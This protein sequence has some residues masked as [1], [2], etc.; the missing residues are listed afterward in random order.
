VVR[1][2]EG[3]KE[4]TQDRSGTSA[5]GPWSFKIVKA[6]NR[7]NS[8]HPLGFRV[9][10]LIGQHEW[11]SNGET[12]RHRCEIQVNLK[13]YV[14]AKNENTPNYESIRKAL[15]DICKGPEGISLEKG[16]A[17][18]QHCPVSGSLG[19]APLVR[20][21]TLCPVRTRRIQTSD[22]ACL[23]CTDAYVELPETCTSLPSF[24]S[25]ASCKNLRG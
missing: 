4:L 16:Y 20:T 24:F 8:P 6:L 25:R 23:G 18:S 15:P 11:T 10:S 3:L 13:S 7:Y 2:C 12:R 9:I 19:Q 5:D 21:R 14:D 17:L 1:R 22:P